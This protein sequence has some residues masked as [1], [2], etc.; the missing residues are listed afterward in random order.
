MKLIVKDEKQKAKDK[1]QCL[2]LFLLYSVILYFLI[3][4]VFGCA[5]TGNIKELAMP[6]EGRV[7]TAIDLQDYSVTVKVSGPFSY[8]LYKSDDP[9]KIIVE[10]LDVSTGVFNNRSNG[11]NRE[12]A[13]SKRNRAC[14]T[15]EGT[16]S[17]GHRNNQYLL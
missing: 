14:F 11:E 5:P 13:R 1:G 17:K 2:R 12:C 4:I 16:P 8:T 15:R 3:F 9:Y 6:D 10:L 7:I